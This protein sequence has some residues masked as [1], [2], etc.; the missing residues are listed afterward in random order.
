MVAP[1]DSRKD[2]AN[3]EKAHKLHFGSIPESKCKVFKFRAILQGNRSHEKWSKGQLK[4]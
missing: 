4:S 3:F 1:H 2:L